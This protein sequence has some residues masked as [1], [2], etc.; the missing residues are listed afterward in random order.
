MNPNQNNLLKSLINSNGKVTSKQLGEMLGLSV[1]TIKNYVAEINDEAGKRIIL[2]DSQGYY[3][4]AD[5]S[6]YL[7]SDDRDIPQNFEER[8][9]KLLRLF[10]LD[11]L[12]RIDI[13]EICDQLCVSEATLRND[14]SRLNKINQT[15]DIV[16]S[17]QKNELVLSG[18]E[19]SI[20]KMYSVLLY[21]SV[22]SGYFDYD[23]IQKEFPDFNTRRIVPIIRR[24]FTRNRYY[25]NEFAL[26][27]MML[28][29]AIIID[30][31]KKKNYLDTYSSLKMSENEKKIVFALCSELE[32]AY[33]VNFT[34]AEQNEIL[35]LVK[36]NANLDVSQDVQQLKKNVGEEVARLVL[37]IEKDIKERYFIDL[38]SPTFTVPFALHIKNL[39]FRLKNHTSIFNPMKES[40]IHSQPIIFEIALS[41]SMKIM[42]TY[43]Y[44]VN[45]NETCF[46][47]L[48]IGG[49][50]ERQK[51]SYSRVRTVLLCPGYM[52]L[53]TQ[54]YNS[55]L[56]LYSSSIK[57]DMVVNNMS[58]IME[59][60]MDLLIS[61]INVPASPGYETAVIS[62]FL[63]SADKEIVQSAIELVRKN[64]LNHHLKK[65]FHNYFD[66]S[67][68]Y[69]KTAET[70]D[71]ESAIRLMSQRLINN[72]FV[73]RDFPE[74]VLA[75]ERA[76]ST[77]FNDVSIPHSIEMDAFR[78]TVSVMICK[79]GIV[80]GG[81]VVHIILLMSISR[82][83][84]EEFSML[85]EALVSMFS[86]NE[87]IRQLVECRTFDEFQKTMFTL[88]K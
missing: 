78:T 59:T 45:D 20:R 32:D 18:P 9:E 10:F 54:L 37:D 65:H 1:R 55:L 21:D 22:S 2:S 7:P 15:F 76:A 31:L 88:I 42:D 57:I 30:R 14:I 17:F 38:S 49:E 66:S 50:I 56:L 85:Y 67:L 86:D 43:G 6:D 5:Y 63:T 53:A 48:H 58:E 73:Q 84:H 47:A 69:L 34:E 60:K 13:D 41:V 26:F 75:R 81:Q 71:N 4:S 80:W 39:L 19:K 79:E 70:T 74:Q 8:K 11:H 16:F 23:L 3:L 61:T 12:T 51:Q 29:V 83:N 72:G 62:P 27:N 87:N 46:I 77:A 28:H 52:N 35:L 33:D 64:K 40:I 24:V 82:E 25:I 44:A 68:F 36:A